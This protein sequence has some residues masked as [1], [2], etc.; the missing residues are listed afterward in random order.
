MERVTGIGGF[1][2]RARD[3]GVLARWYAEHLGVDEV[4]KTYEAR[5]WHQEGGTT[6]FAPF[7]ADTDYFGDPDQVWMINF[8]VPDLPAIVAQLTAAEIAVE[9]D[10]EFHPNGRFARMEDPEGNPIELWEPAFRDADVEVP[11]EIEL[12]FRHVARFNQ[13]V[14]TGDFRSM[15]E[16]FGE[17]AELVFEDGPVGPF[18]GRPGIE[19]AFADRPPDDEVMILDK[20]A[21]MDGVVVARYGWRAGGGEAGGEMRLTAAG[22]LIQRLVITSTLRG[23]VPR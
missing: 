9:L 15:L 1:F 6:V 4:P 8:R 10:P 3:P 7:E 23:S 11:A 2:F 16:Q 17:T 12:F 21:L 5:T 18:A 22:G 20:P 19:A 14:K 13:G